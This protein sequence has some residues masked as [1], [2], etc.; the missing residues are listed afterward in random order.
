MSIGTQEAV[1]FSITVNQAS[2]TC[3][4]FSPTRGIVYRSCRCDGQSQ[5][6][7]NDIVD[8]GF[9]SFKDVR[10][11]Q[12]DIRNCNFMQ[13][14]TYTW[15]DNQSADNVRYGLA[16]LQYDNKLFGKFCFY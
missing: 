2:R 16:I 14:V 15:I 9:H 5:D 7:F 8:F 10:L 6:L 12:N 11:K 1:P 13:V 3:R 4:R